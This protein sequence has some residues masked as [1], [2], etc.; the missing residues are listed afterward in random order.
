VAFPRKWEL[1]PELSV[2]RGKA[3]KNKSSRNQID[4]FF[5]VFII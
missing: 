5:I 3:L 1:L 2:E 4:C